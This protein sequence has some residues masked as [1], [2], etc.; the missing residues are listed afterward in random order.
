M[1]EGMARP[2]E[3]YEER[4]DP[5]GSMTKLIASRIYVFES[6][7][8]A[9]VG[10]TIFP[11]GVSVMVRPDSSAIWGLPLKQVSVEGDPVVFAFEEEA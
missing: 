3:A 7:E 1:D 4:L 8:G 5:G 10:V 6:D 9:Q 11:D 2:V